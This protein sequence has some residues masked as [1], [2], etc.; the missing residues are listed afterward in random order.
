MLLPYASHWPRVG[1]VE[2]MRRFA[3]RFSYSTV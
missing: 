1:H 3:A 2:N